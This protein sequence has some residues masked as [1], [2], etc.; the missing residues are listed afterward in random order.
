[1]LDLTGQQL[2][3]IFMKMKLHRKLLGRNPFSDVSY[4]KSGMMLNG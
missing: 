4:R 3:V 2:F 1:V